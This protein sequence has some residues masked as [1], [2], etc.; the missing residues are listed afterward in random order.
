MWKIRWKTRCK[1]QVWEMMDYVKQKKVPAQYG[2][3]DLEHDLK[4]I[5]Q[6]A[7]PFRA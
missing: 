5:H 3:E 4:V 2:L 7:E 1:T 6:R